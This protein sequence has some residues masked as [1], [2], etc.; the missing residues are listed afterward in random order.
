MPAI[1]RSVA[2]L[3]IIGA[4]LAPGEVTRL[5]GGAPAFTQ[6]KGQSIRNYPGAPERVAQFGMWS[7]RA[8]ERSPED[9]DSQIEEL[10]SGLTSDLSV[11]RAITAKFKADIFCG[12]FM[13]LSNEG[14]SLKPST[15]VA[16]GSRGIEIGFDL[17][18]PNTT[19]ESKP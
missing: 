15:L 6:T 8:T 7:R 1:A 14:F 4:D 10:L 13:S 2:S 9:L 18:S 19:P 5:L 17:Y 11:W 16:L 12:L 3:R